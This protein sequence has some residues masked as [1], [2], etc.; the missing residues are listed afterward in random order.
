MQCIYLHFLPSLNQVWQSLIPH[1]RKFIHAVKIFVGFL[2]VRQDVCRF[3]TRILQFWKLAVIVVWPNPYLDTVPSLHVHT[4]HVIFHTAVCAIAH[5]HCALH[6]V[7]YTGKLHN[8]TAEVHF[9]FLTEVV[10]RAPLCTLCVPL[11]TVFAEHS[12]IP[13]CSAGCMDRPTIKAH[14]YKL[15]KGF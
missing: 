2:S 13:L 10:A 11:W 12:I 3:L 1:V 14:K 7:C 4:K 9:I 5:E 6:I 8:D 15:S